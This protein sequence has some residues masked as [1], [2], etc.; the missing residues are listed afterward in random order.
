MTLGT[1]F[2]TASVGIIYQ[3]W[4]KFDCR[5]AWLAGCTL[6]I[7]IALFLLFSW[8]TYKYVNRQRAIA[9]DYQTTLSAHARKGPSPIPWWKRDVPYIAIGAVLFF[10]FALWLWS[11]VGQ[12]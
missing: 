7:G 12:P 11:R 1:F 8:L 6:A 4:D 9:L 5:T 3:R 2:L 10:V